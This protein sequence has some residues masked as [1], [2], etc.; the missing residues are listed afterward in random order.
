MPKPTGRFPL[1]LE[2]VGGSLV[3]R[4]IFPGFTNGTQQVRYFSFLSWVFWTFEIHRRHQVPIAKLP[5]HQRRWRV[6]LEHAFRCCSQYHSLKELGVPAR[7]LIGV[8]KTP[9]LAD[10]PSSTIVKLAGEEITKIASGTDAATYGSAFAALGFAVPKEGIFQLQKAGIEAG[11]AFDATV[12]ESFSRSQIAAFDRLLDVTSEITVAELQRIAESFRLRR[13]NATE[14]ESRVLS[15][16][17]MRLHAA[18]QRPTPFNEEDRL[19]ALGLARILD[20]VDQSNGT[21]TRPDDCHSIFSRRRFL[22]RRSLTTKP[23]LVDTDVAWQRYEERQHEKL[24]ISAFWHETLE[25]LESEYAPAQPAAVIVAHCIALLSRSHV[26]KEW[27]GQKAMSQTVTSAIERIMRGASERKKTAM[28]L[29]YEL[30]EEIRN[31]VGEPDATAR[32]GNAVVCLLLS[33]GSWRDEISKEGREYHQQGGPARLSLSWMSEQLALRGSD[34]LAELV[35]WVVEWCVLAQAIRIAYEKT[36]AAGRVNR[37]FIERGD[38][39]YRIVQMHPRN[40]R[41]PYDASRLDGAFGLLRTVGFLRRD[42][43]GAYILTK[44]GRAQ[45]QALKSEYVLMQR[46]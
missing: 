43:G 32:L 21:I 20:V 37:F 34:S 35:R 11:E 42:E 46:Q 19:R 36:D 16:V 26:L 3:A 2:A 12:R 30:T 24:A 6:R 25:F 1:G 41:L 4:E 9:N 23:P 28:E 38:G 15:R 13:L 39:G 27:L 18:D 31:L 33:V 7:G 10:L 44:A 22:D 5:A 14:S 17:L 45:L 29:G 40:N 8:R